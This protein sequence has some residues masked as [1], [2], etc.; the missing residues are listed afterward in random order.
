MIILTAANKDIIRN[1]V[2]GKCSDFSFRKVITETAQNARRFG[3]VPVIYDLGELGIGELYYEEDET[4]QKEGYYRE[5]Q[6]GYQ[7]K[8]LFK[9]DIV[10][11][12]LEE[13]NDFTVYLDGDALLYKRIDEVEGN[14]YDI[15]VT[16]RPP[17]EM[18]SQWYE[19]HKKIVRYLNAGVIFINPTPAALQFIKLWKIRTAEVGNDQQALNELACPDEYPENN[20]I[21]ELNGAR[22]KYFPCQIYNN[23]YFDE[24]VVKG[25]KILHFKGVVRRYYPFDWKTRLYCR[26]VAFQVYRLKKLVKNVQAHK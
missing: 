6:Q 7:S 5:V 22:I 17:F 18:E 25:L 15:G 9:P 10:Q 21:I 26:A 12:C 16:L 3:Y 2:G 19:D 20:S 11:K 14:D 13:H 24:G 4:F 8:S 1:C 23:Y